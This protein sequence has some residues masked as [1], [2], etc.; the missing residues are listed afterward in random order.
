MAETRVTAIQTELLV[1]GAAKVRVSAVQ[2]LLLTAS[3][4]PPAT[5]EDPSI[6]QAG[7]HYPRGG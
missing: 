6:A 5:T 7:Q 4:T 1:T 2:F 3:G